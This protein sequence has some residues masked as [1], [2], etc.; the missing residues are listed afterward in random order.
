MLFIQIDTS[1][2]R[3]LHSQVLDARRALE[4]PANSYFYTF[5]L[6]KHGSPPSHNEL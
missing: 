4:P 3:R 1:L 5:L 6:K 2:P